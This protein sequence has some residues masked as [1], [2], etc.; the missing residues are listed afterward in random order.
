VQ[1]VQ[2]IV[3]ARIGHDVRARKRD[4]SE[5]ESVQYE[6]ALR[7]VVVLRCAADTAQALDQQEWSECTVYSTCAHRT[8]QRDRLLLRVVVVVVR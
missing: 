3:R 6:V 7:I 1:L 5:G 2:C 8:I 4:T